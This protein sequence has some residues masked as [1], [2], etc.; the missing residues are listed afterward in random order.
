MLDEEA[1]EPTVTLSQNLDNVAITLIPEQQ[2]VLDIVKHLALYSKMLIAVTG[3]HGSGKTTLAHELLYS[4]NHQEDIL[5]IDATI[6]LGVPAILRRLGDVIQ[7]PI[8]ENR[9]MAIEL[10]RIQAEQRASIGRSLIIM[11]DQ[12]EQLDADTINELAEVALQIPEGFAIVLFG[13]SGYEDNLLAAAN[14][15]PVHVQRIQPLSEYGAQLLLQQVYSPGQP[16]PLS[17]QEFFSVYQQSKGVVGTLLSLASDLF[18]STT[19]RTA[20]NA[21]NAKTKT[22]LKEYFPVTHLFALLF[23][24]VALLLSYLYNPSKSTEK[25]AEIE[26]LESLDML[27]GMPLPQKDTAADFN[28]DE[29]E[30]VA[31]TAPEILT[32]D[33]P[34]LPAEKIVEPQVS[35]QSVSK[36]VDV[37]ERA[38]PQQQTKPEVETEATPTNKLDADKLLSIKKGTVVQLFGSYEQINAENFKQD[39]QKQLSDQLYIYQTTNKGKPW[40]VV[41]VGSYSDKKAAGQAIKTW[42]AELQ[43]ASP[44]IRDIK[45]V[46]ESLR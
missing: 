10:L 33:E 16:L 21:K 32:I 26:Q 17:E 37:A 46:Q 41:V 3:P 43:K 8:P 14:Q 13:L 30:T 6:M 11:I 40:F 18:L 38:K 2:Q 28:F 31:V 4:S 34:Q 7:Q 25:P 20:P 42:P 5:I 15:A 12:A 44:W 24:L 19:E 39:W 35:S 29:D 9:T 23:L 45:V 22:T 36:P 1:F 27:R